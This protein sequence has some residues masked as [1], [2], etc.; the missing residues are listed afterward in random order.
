MNSAGAWK[1]GDEQGFED[2]KKHPVLIGILHGICIIIALSLPVA[3]YW[4][5]AAF[6]AMQVVVGFV[7]MV[8]WPKLRHSLKTFRA[9][10]Y[11]HVREDTGE[12]KNV[13]KAPSRATAIAWGAAKR[14]ADHCIKYGKPLDELRTTLGHEGLLDENETKFLIR[15]AIQDH[16]KSHPELGKVF[17]NL[18]RD[19]KL[20][21]RKRVMEDKGY[22]EAAA[23]A[24]ARFWFTVGYLENHL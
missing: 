19:E 5:I 10:A 4:R 20:V 3:W 8:L 21:F 15:S 13:G 6:F 22:D 2:A 14:R 24:F 18:P 12:R 7:R 16:L 17:D 9:A 23:D 1:L 11:A